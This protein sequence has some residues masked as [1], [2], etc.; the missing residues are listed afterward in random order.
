[1]L[2]G[3]GIWDPILKGGWTMR[4]AGQQN[5]G[6]HAVL[7]AQAGPSQSGQAVSGGTL[8]AGAKLRTAFPVFAAALG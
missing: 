6:L 4:M 8:V 1:M 3:L 2:F 5:E 7:E